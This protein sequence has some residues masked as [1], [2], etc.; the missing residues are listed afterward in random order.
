VV[1]DMKKKGPVPEPLPQ[2]PPTYTPNA[3]EPGPAMSGINQ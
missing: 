1:E 3:P 2:V